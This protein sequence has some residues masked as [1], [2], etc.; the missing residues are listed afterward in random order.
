MLDL[1]SVIELASSGMKQTR[2]AMRRARLAKGIT[3]DALSRT[4]GVPQ[5]TLSTL[6]NRGPT[7]GILT[8]IKL[9]RA[10][11]RSVEDLFGDA[12][13]QPEPARP[14]RRR[15]TAVHAPGCERQGA[16]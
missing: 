6:E 2:N 10:L 8:A 1:A 16:D 11:G 5:R 7:Q 12:L 4:T 9:A 14:T 3:Q 15:R 13:A